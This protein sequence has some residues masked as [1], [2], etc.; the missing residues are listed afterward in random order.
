MF[1]NLLDAQLK[2]GIH[3]KD[4][5]QLRPHSALG[6]NAPAEVATMKA[7]RLMMPLGYQVGADHEQERKHQGHRGNG[8]LLPYVEGRVGSLT[9]IL[10]SAVGDQRYLLTD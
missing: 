10:E 6:Y 7:G 4:T 5:N 3:R 2:P 9:P 8:K 1:F